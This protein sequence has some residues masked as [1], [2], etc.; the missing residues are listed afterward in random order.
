M[1]NLSFPVL[2]R[3]GI[4]DRHGRKRKNVISAPAVLY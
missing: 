3:N 2:V 1:P 4:P